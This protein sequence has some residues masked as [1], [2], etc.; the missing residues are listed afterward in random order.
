MLFFEWKFYKFF[1]IF[2]T[3]YFFL[4][5]RVKNFFL[6]GASYWFYGSWNWK[7]LGL[8]LISTAVD[9]QVG[10]W[11]DSQES[12]K[13][14]K[15]LLVLS[16]AT[17]LGILGVF[18]YYDFFISNVV[19]GL[20][21]MGL[22]PDLPLL[23]LILPPGIS[24]YT[25]QTL[26]YTIDVYRRKIPH[27]KNLIDFA[28]YV[29]FFPQLIA[30]PIERAENLLEQFKKDREITLVGCT[31]GVR[32]FVWGLFKKL[33]VADN[34]AR[35]A[36]PIFKDPGNA[37]PV[38]L[39]FGVYAFAFQIYCDFSG[40]TDMA[41]GLGKMLGFD[42]SINFNLP[43]F[44][45]S[46]RNFWQRWH[47]T[48]STWLRDYIYIPLGGSREGLNKTVVNLMVT[49]AL[50]GLWH[51]AAWNYIFWGLYNGILMGL[52]RALEETALTRTWRKMPVPFR[53]LA[54]FHLIGIGWLIFRCPDMA[55]LELYSAHLFDLGSWSLAGLEKNTH[56]V[57]KFFVFVG[58]LLFI[59]LLQYKNNE[60]TVDFH[61]PAW[62]KGLVYAVLVLLLVYM[63]PMDGKQ[64]IYFQF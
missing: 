42:L 24:F 30:G 7:F 62:L 17:N 55:T 41:R 16:I 61:W 36:D 3:V 29:S 6:L 2:F 49:M 57:L 38:A 12:L 9:Y 14:R 47:I 11:L 18:K 43:H 8:L 63:S 59:Q 56:V 54:T 27:E 23:E 5:R 39:L 4:P 33:F 31:L 15:Q 50:C 40:Y 60:H 48:L 26:S 45:T 52:E 21:G 35:L 22:Q 37:D 34:L 20:T 53:M 19:A 28:A 10:K 44:A 64:F 32:L 25:F 51:G 46:V 1:I 58:P 13:K